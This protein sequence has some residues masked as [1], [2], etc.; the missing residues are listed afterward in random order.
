MT[1][2]WK[3][4]FTLVPGSEV[5][6]ETAKEIQPQLDKIVDVVYDHINHSNFSTKINEAY[7][8]VGISTGVLT[9]EESSRPESSL[10]FDSVPIEDIYFEKSKDGIIDNVFKE[11]KIRIDEIEEVIPNASIPDKMMEMLAKDPAAEVDMIEAV[12]KNKNMMYDQVIWWVHEEGVQIAEYS[13]NDT[14]PYIVFREGVDARGEFG[15]GRIIQLLHEI[16]VLNTV[17][18]LELQNASLAIGGAYTAMDD[19]IFNPYTTRI[20]PGA[21]IPVASNNN[22][23]PTLRPLERSGDYQISQLQID[24]YQERINRYMFN[25]PLG[26]VET[27][28][29]RTA[30]EV[31]ARV[32]DEIELSQSSWARFQTELLE[33][34]IKRVIDILQKAGKIAPI[35]VDGKEITIKFTSPLAK[36]QDKE[37]INTMLEFSQVMTATGIPLETLGE[38]VKYEDMPEFISKM[39]GVPQQ[40]MRTPLEK[41]QYRIQ[42]AQALQLQQQQ[43]IP[44]EE[45]V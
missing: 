17:V 24:R 12:I 32:S 4:W 14:S 9:V 22:Q 11:F 44:Q 37:E 25:E 40:L 26:K 6:E 1:P 5:D 34:L 28:P 31:S 33:R 13:N 2:A 16:R 43:E 27:A 7:Q 8:D 18:S 45:G 36:Q 23:N 19:G 20:E 3:K 38:S 42:Q 30:T 10:M 29:V 21:V 39:M 15:R 35:V 41:Q